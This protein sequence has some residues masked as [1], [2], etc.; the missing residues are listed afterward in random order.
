ML[1]GGCGPLARR[2][3]DEGT[4]TVVTVGMMGEGSP[5]LHDYVSKMAKVHAQYGDGDADM[6][7]AAAA[8]AKR[9]FYHTLSCTSVR[10]RA[11]LLR[12][13][14]RLVQGGQPQQQQ[15]RDAA[16]QARAEAATA[17]FPPARQV[18]ADLERLQRDR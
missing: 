6:Q 11:L 5:S 13:R 17:A 3:R 8:A 15:R 10:L 18:R 2:F 9:V 14:L 4:Y 16:A 7:M 1:G 12:G